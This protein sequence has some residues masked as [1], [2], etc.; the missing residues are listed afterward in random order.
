M[1]DATAADRGT[2]PSPG[3]PRGPSDEGPAPST[4]PPKQ[5]AAAAGGGE[6]GGEEGGE[7][8]AD[9]DADGTG[10]GAGEPAVRRRLPLRGPA[11]P[12]RPHRPRGDAAEPAAGQV[13]ALSALVAAMQ[14]GGA[15]LGQTAALASLLA[16]SL[17]YALIAN[18]EA[19]YVT[20]PAPA[21]KDDGKAASAGPP[22]DVLPS[23]PVLALLLRCTQQLL[24]TVGI[25]A[26][27]RQEA[28]LRRVYV[29]LLTRKEMPTEKRY[30]VLEAL[31]G[32]F[33]TLPAL[34]LQLFAAYECS[35]ARGDM[36][37]ALVDALVE[38][39]SLGVEGTSMLALEALLD[40][41]AASTSEVASAAALPP[42][43][44]ASAGATPAAPPAASLVALREAKVV[45]SAAARTFNDKPKHGL[46][47]IQ[48]LG[49]VASP[50]DA[51]EVARFL[52]ATPQISKAALGDFLSEPKPFNASV[53][54]EF[55]ALLDFGALDIDGALRVFLKTF[56][57]PGEAQKID[58][59]MD[60]FAAA[61]FTANP[62][63]P[64]A[65]PD[66][67]YV[68]AFAI[69]MLNTDSHNPSI[70]PE[71]KMTLEGF[72][73]QVAGANDN[74]DFPRPLLER[75][76]HSIQTDEIRMSE[77]EIRLSKGG[78]RSMGT[79]LP[80]APPPAASAAGVCAAGGG[81]G[82]GGGGAAP[83]LEAAAAAAAA[84]AAVAD[85]LALTPAALAQL[86]EAPVRA[87]L[88]AIAAPPT[89]AAL[90]AAL[91]RAETREGIQ[92]TLDAYRRCAA[93]AAEHQDAQ[94]LH[95][96]MAA[97]GSASGLTPQLLG[98]GSGG[99]GGGGGAAAMEP[100]SPGRGSVVTPAAP[101]STAGSGTAPPSAD[102][103]AAARVVVVVVVVVVPRG[104]AARRR[105]TGR[106]RRRR[107]RRRVLAPSARKRLPQKGMLCAAALFSL[108][109]VCSHSFR[110][111]SEPAAAAGGGGGGGGPWDV[112]VEA[113]MGLHQ[114]RLLPDDLCDDPTLGRAWDEAPPAPRHE[115]GKAPPA[116]KAQSSFSLT[117]LVGFLI[118]VDVNA[119]DAEAAARKRAEEAAKKEVGSFGLGAL[120][121]A[122]AA[123]PDESLHALVD[124]LVHAATA[125]IAATTAN[126][127][128]KEGG[129]G[130]ATPELSRGPSSS[131]AEDAAGTT[132]TPDGGTTTPRRPDSPGGKAQHAA[133]RREALALQLLAHLAIHSGGRFGA[134]WPRMRVAF[135]GALT[136]SPP[137]VRSAAVALLRL[138]LRAR[139]GGGGGATLDE[140]LPNLAPLRQ[141]QGALP[142]ATADAIGAAVWELCR[143]PADARAGVRRRRR[144]RRRALRSERRQHGA[145]SS[146]SPPRRI[147]SPRPRPPR[148]A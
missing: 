70:K 143:P 91:S 41:L 56:R 65:K 12:H 54:T 136:E 29:A 85:G 114:R 124:A 122:S 13:F 72:V 92:H 81:G 147:S 7:G 141:Q 107:R 80:A 79:A 90:Q 120:L 104:V 133:A 138:L 8:A 145:S 17:A 123:L 42:P 55:T 130:G 27:D 100:T 43:A 129:G 35:G 22:P 9:A 84:A 148:R 18:V 87:A 52:R 53:L 45:V 21:P 63:G 115:A 88:F 15:P 68:L 59:L 38:A 73:R 10:A 34:P 36:L 117:G 64:I 62:G 108:T 14:A 83:S 112:V 111:L 11:L 125:T 76:Y 33:A 126:G 4:P 1:S 61:Y 46:E 119:D 137:L 127:V 99:G 6:G 139:G 101:L 44:D 30:I 60:A 95:T 47:Q 89:L 94:T 24:S 75:I 135:D 31:P 121:D 103:A 37:S 26:S 57:L 69:I 74:K 2:P 78:W 51:P 96:I 132:P 131:A 98:G 40:V 116:A 77:E 93:I 32:L 106:R 19:S 118:G 144:R 105:Q 58:R 20:A 71:N 109:S 49:L 102:D 25:L 97:L 23:S 146:P 86:D 3:V 128:A 134:L 48:T 28:L 5:P 113:L 16:D 67:A 110:A 66:A 82:G 39:R 142:P 50:P 140:L